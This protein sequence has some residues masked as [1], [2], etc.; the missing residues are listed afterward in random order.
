MALIVTLAGAVNVA[1]FAGA[2][3]LTVGGLFL[4][5]T[6]ERLGHVVEAIG[7]TPDVC[8]RPLYRERAIRVSGTAC[9]TDAANVVTGP[10]ARQRRGR[11]K[12]CE[13]YFEAR[14]GS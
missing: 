13:K 8:A 14:R 6:V 10:R 5:I 7:R 9:H 2:V 4:P 1:G 12:C 11:R 3:M